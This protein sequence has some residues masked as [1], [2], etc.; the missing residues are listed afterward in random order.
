MIAKGRVAQRGEDAKIE[1]KFQSEKIAGTI[2]EN[3]G[4][5]NYKE[6][7]SIQSVKA[8][9]LLAVKTPPTPGI[10]GVDVFGNII[11][12]KPGSEKDLKLAGNVKVSDDGLSFTRI[13]S[14]NVCYTKLLRLR[15]HQARIRRRRLV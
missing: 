2:D 3:S 5:I 6:R 10:E 9:M 1:L 12:T 15:H 13:T 7:K 8:E 14:Y 11:P 4:I